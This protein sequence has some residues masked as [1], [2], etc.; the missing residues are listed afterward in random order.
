M[1][2]S[3]D[4]QLWRA[5]L[6][7]SPEQ[8]QAFRAILSP[9]ERDRADH[10]AFV[11][12]ARRFIVARGMLRRLLGSY[13]GL[14]PGRLVFRYGPAGKPGLDLRFG[15]DLDFNVSHSADLAVY[16]MTRGHE[17][18]VDIERVRPGLPVEEMA[19]R[20]F[21]ASEAA[22]LQAMPSASRRDAFFTCWT[23]KEAFV[24]A[25]G[26]GLQCR[27]RD[28]DVAVSPGEPPALL[29]LAGVP[30]APAQWEF[31]HLRPAPG[32]VGTVVTAGRGW[33]LGD[34]QCA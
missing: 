22:A 5:S 23:R 19:A 28:F 20:F 27:L 8:V 15:R 31:H 17:V 2:G 33:H 13:L 26:D 34:W 7:A 14:P 21:S 4:V 1:I 10:F 9:D 18:G 30:A 32:Y 29:R 12:S 25:R 11:D 16:A 6:E 24:K 3:H